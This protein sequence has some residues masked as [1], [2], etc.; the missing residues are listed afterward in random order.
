M[1]KEFSFKIGIIITSENELIEELSD[2]L[3]SNTDYC[4]GD[5]NW[6]DSFKMTD[7]DLDGLL[8]K[9]NCSYWFPQG[10]G[11]YARIMFNDE[12]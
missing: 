9:Y 10:E 6:N 8:S 11:Y 3:H 1:L 5:Y 2:M 7:E 12:T 4:E